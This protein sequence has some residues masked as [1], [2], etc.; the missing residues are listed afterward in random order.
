MFNIFALVLA[1]QDTNPKL[2]K[3]TALEYAG[4]VKEASDQSGI[5]PWLFHAIIKHETSWNNNKSVR[6]ETDGTCSI[7]LGQINLKYC[8]SKKRDILLNPHYNILLMG[9]TLFYMKGFC[10]KNCANYGWL[11]YYNPGDPTYAFMAKREMRR[12][13][14]AYK[15]NA[16]DLDAMTMNY[17]T[18][19]YETCDVARPMVSFTR[20]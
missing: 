4:W 7:G 16:F 2:S 20:D 19:K 14:A 13:E 6:H 8:W 10:K 17:L 9:E 18:A 15:P 5:D 1:I 3:E 11:R 12:A